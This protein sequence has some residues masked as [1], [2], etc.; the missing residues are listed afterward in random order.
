MNS[1]GTWLKTGKTSRSETRGPALVGR[2]LGSGS[3][4]LARP[5]TDCLVVASS[6]QADGLV[7]PRLPHLNRGHGCRSRVAAW[8][9]F[10]NRHCG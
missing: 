9:D 8:R 10:G 1:S 2:S 4:P 6:H 5:L 3:R 7:G